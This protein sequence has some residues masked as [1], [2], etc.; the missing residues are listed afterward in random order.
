MW[1]GGHFSSGS[2]FTPWGRLRGHEARKA[3]LT[4]EKAGPNRGHS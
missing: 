2:G 1:G 4:A 3:S